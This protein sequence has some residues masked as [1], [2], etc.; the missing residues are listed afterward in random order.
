MSRN[1]RLKIKLDSKEENHYSEFMKEEVSI[2]DYI[3]SQAD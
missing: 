3:S 2:I 1:V